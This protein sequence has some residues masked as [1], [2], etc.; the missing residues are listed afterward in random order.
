MQSNRQKPLNHFASKN[1]HDQLV[2]GK[3]TRLRNQC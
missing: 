2:E 1:I 3:S